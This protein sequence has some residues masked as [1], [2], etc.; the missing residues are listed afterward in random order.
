MEQA[1]FYLLKS[2]TWM[3]G[4][5]LLYLLFLRK[6]RFF[7]LKRIYLLSGVVLSM[8]LP[9]VTLHYRIELPAPMVQETP[10]LTTILPSSTEAAAEIVEETDP[11][12]WFM[13]IYA[14]GIL[15]LLGRTLQYL[16][17]VYR[18]VRNGPVDRE[19]EALLVRTEKYTSA[20]S[21]FNYVFHQSF[22]ERGGGQGDPEP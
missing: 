22:S 10:G 7:T 4:F 9:L 5:T 20:F 16:F 18:M 14:A 3:A 15:F 8:L 1:A 19:G 17:S 6:E 2:A 13:I 11:L 21:F 12:K